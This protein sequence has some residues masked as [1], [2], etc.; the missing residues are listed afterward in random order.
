[1]KTMTNQTDMTTH[2]QGST[3]GGLEP[4][5]RLL[6]VRHCFLAVLMVV[7]PFS[8]AWSQVVNEVVN[9]RNRTGTVAVNAGERFINPGEFSIITEGVG[10]HGILGGDNVEVINNGTIIV[11]GAGADGIRVWHR[12]SGDQ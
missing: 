6:I 1:M 4:G 12:W 7:L 11:R 3:L 10:E 5:L 9:D 8:P 2:A